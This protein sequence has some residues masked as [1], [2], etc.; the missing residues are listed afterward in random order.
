[1]DKEG[2]NS[3]KLTDSKKL[4]GSFLLSDMVDKRKPRVWNLLDKD[5]NILQAANMSIFLFVASVL[6]TLSIHCFL[7]TIPYIMQTLKATIVLQSQQLLK[8]KAVSVALD[9]QCFR[10]QFEKLNVQGL[11]CFQFCMEEDTDLAFGRH[12]LSIKL[13][14]P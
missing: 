3:R 13:T 5:P 8:E 10:L 4:V 1:M 6:Y 2:R 11:L 7:K 14:E 9:R 12:L